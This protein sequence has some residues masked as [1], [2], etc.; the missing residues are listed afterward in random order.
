MRIPAELESPSGTLEM[1]TAAKVTRLTA[2]P[3]TNDTPMTIDSGM[4][5]S[6]APMDGK[7]AAFVLARLLT[8]GALAMPGAALGEDAVRRG[9]HE[10]AGEEA[11]GSREEAAA[12]VGLVHQLE[13]QGQDQDAAAEGHDGGD[14]AL[15]QVHEVSDAGTDQQRRAAD[16]APEPDL[17][18]E[19]DRGKHPDVR[20]VPPYRLAGTRSGWAAAKAARSSARAANLRQTSSICSGVCAADT[21]ARKRQVWLGVPGGSARLT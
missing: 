21:L 16:E 6:S 20:P 19:R 15:R 4:P 7:A 14:Q 3:A 10:R 18:P 1:K 2:P 17:G 5:S 12:A 11:R 13:R 9:V 8:A